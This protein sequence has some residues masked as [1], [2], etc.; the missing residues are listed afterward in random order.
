MHGL[1]AVRRRASVFD[2]L[3]VVRSLIAKVGG[4]LPAD[5]DWMLHTLAPAEARIEASGF[6]AVPAMATATPPVS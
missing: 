5:F 3:A 6:D 4:A 2:D 1:S